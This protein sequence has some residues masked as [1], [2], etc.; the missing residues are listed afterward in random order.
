MQS[1]IDI[2]S[3]IVKLRA[4]GS[5]FSLEGMREFANALGN[6]QESLKILHIAGTNGKGSTSAFC[7]AILRAHGFKTGM[8]TSPHLLKI[9]ERIQI[10]RCEISD[11][12]FAKQFEILERA[13]AKLTQN[14]SVQ[15][16]TFFEYMTA[17]AFNYFKEK[18]TDF[19]VFEV[20]MGGR[21]DSTNIANPQICAITSIALEHTQF[22]GDTIEKIAREKAGI[23]KQ[24]T[25]VVC[26]IMPQEALLEIEK[27]AAQK[28][29]PLYKLEDFYTR[30]PQFDTS[31]EA[32]Y[33]KTNAA[34]AFLIC[35]ILAEGKFD[36]SEA[37]AK[38]AIIGTKWAARWQKIKLKDGATL[39][40]DCSHNVEGAAELEKNLSNL[41]QKSGGKK[42]IIASGIL[43]KDRAL[44][45]LKV[46]SK[47][48][49]KIVFL[50]PNEDRALSFEELK[51]CLPPNH[52]DFQNAEICDIFSKD[53]CSLSSESDCVICTGSCYLAGE[54]LARISASKRD[55]LQDILP[56]K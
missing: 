12:D 56:K 26:G 50:K 6:P 16:P 38:D 34:L 37:K 7:E 48:A 33:Q 35:K 21:L 29:A 41:L 15:S 18:S 49:K 11:E 47:Y 14:K 36:F 23:I 22:L 24:N 19:A 43:G 51:E 28:N 9:N 10:N 55:N 27:I 1:K 2:E 25:P 52:P 13:T 8:F 39:I 45:L 32:S 3:R 53:F 42:P 20:G 30:N 4:A 54:V 40:L 44:A 17:M 31:F 46:I 5:K